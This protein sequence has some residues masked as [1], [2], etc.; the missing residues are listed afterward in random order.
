ML[1]TA[2][3]R[4]APTGVTPAQAARVADLGSGALPARAPAAVRAAKST[5]TLANTHT[6]AVRTGQPLAASPAD[7]LAAVV[8]AHTIATVGRADALPR[9]ALLK[10]R[11][12]PAEHTAAWI[13]PTGEG[14]AVRQLRTL[15]RWKDTVTLGTRLANRAR[16]ADPLALVVAALSSVALWLANA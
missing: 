16:A 9:P 2:T 4:A 13:G 8:P 15:R 10:R 14:V 5:V 1:R 12:P 6:P 11:T 3:G 7:A